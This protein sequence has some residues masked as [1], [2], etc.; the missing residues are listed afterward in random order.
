MSV[1]YEHIDGL[2]RARIICD[3]CEKPIRDIHD[4][5]VLIEEPAVGEDVDLTGA[6]HSHKRPECQAKVR[7]SVG[8]KHVNGMCDDLG[9]FLVRIAA[10]VGMYPA[11]F[12]ERFE[13]LL[14]WGEVTAPPEDEA[15]ACVDR[16]M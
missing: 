16:E 15:E 13:T 7:A 6:R 5:I 9:T 8:H 11:D 14:R 2:T 4:G 10:D 3:A 1:M 12:Q